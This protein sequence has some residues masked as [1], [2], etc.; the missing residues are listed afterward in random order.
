VHIIT[1]KRAVPIADALLAPLTG[2][3]RLHLV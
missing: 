1:M 3:V 2:D